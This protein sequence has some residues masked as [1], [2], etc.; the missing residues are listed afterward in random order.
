MTIRVIETSTTERNR[1][2]EQ[3][4]KEVKPLLDEGYSYMTALIE[5]GKVTPNLRPHAYT[6]GW[7]NDLK[8]YGKTQGYPYHMYRWRRRK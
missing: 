8:E 7:F 2:T 6:T 1:E 3:L 4:F 5:I